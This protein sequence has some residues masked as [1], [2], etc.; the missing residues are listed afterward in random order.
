MLGGKGFSQ[1]DWC[2]YKTKGARGNERKYFHS[3]SLSLSLSLACDSI[4]NRPS[5]EIELVR[6]FIWTFQLPEWIKNNLCCLRYLVCD[7]F[8]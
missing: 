5:S 2:P 8:L 3:L 1:W 6:S 4:A 7:N